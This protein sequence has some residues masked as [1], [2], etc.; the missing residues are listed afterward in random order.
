VPAALAPLAPPGRA[1]E[2]VPERPPAAPRPRVAV[3]KAEDDDP[4]SDTNGVAFRRAKELVERAERAFDAKQYE[5][6][7]RLYEQANRAVPCVTAAC[8]GR[9]AYCKLHAVTQAL[10]RPGSD[11]PTEELEREVRLALQMSPQMDPAAKRL[12]DR[13]RRRDGAD[14]IEVKHSPRQGGGWARAETTN[15]RI[16]H[17]TSPETAERAAR[18]A[19]ATRLAMT[20]KWFGEAPATWSPRC[21]IYLHSTAQDYS[22]AT[23][24]PAQTPGH[25]TISREGGRI[26]RRRVDLHCDDP[27]MLTGVLPHETTHVIL[28]GRFGS[29]DVP[30]WADEGMAVLSEPR[31][32]I[33]L[34]LKNLPMH[35]REGTLFGVGQLM[36]MSDYPEPRFVG[37]FYAQSVALVEFLSRRKDG[38]TF[39]RFL[40][41]GLDGGYEPALRKHY[42]INGF[43]ELQRLWD[44]HAF[45]AGVAAASENRR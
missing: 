24:A 9:W 22:K 34:H 12:L 37:P 45:G 43:A 16:F 44:E 35:R 11:A 29:H 31:E 32:R 2:A 17:A 3:G 33:E 4:F 39:T 15:F 5:L 23:G 6:A 20:R 36:R 42:G 10:N 8:E 27:N 7:H 38:A 21:D 26:L 1:P 18:V 25:S 40:R 19:E 30:R 14:R 41:D 28:A 13:L